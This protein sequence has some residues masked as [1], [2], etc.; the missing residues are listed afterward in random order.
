MGLIRL[1]AAPFRRVASSHLFQF[2]IVIAFILLLDHYAYDYAALRAIADALK[3]VVTATVQLFSDY[4]RVGVLT[5]PLLQVALEIA[6]VYLVC[7]LI[8]F[9]LRH[10]TRK[11]IDV[12]GR[13]NFLWL[14]TAIARERGIAAY[15][16][17]LQLERIRPDEYPQDEWEQQFAWPADNRPPYPPLS[18]RM[19]RGA[20]SY[21][22]V[23][24][25]AAILLQLFTPLRVLTWLG[26]LI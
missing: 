23:L 13:S 12:V 20:L 21:A 11:T 14:R 26:Q 10:A 2:A 19:L 16:A 15:R 4:F 25:T 7:L 24:A 22:A 17:W 8:F 1:I 5:D 18:R 9:L 3:K 6:Y